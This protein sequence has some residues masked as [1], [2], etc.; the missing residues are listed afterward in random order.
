ML[1][2]IVDLWQ[3][4]RWIR[5]YRENCAQ[6]GHWTNRLKNSD[7]ENIKSKIINIH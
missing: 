4:L 1:Q 5:N 2:N 7:F 3:D 6:I